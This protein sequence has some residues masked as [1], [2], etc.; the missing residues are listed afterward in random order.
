MVGGGERLK[1]KII[2]LLTLE[3]TGHPEGE[4]RGNMYLL[5]K[6]SC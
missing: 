1:S 3:I 4:I 6:E 5:L 2:G